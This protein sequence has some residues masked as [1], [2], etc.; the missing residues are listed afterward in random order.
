MFTIIILGYNLA[1]FLIMLST[2][3]IRLSRT[4]DHMSNRPTK[5]WPLDDEH[6][7]IANFCQALQ[8]NNSTRSALIQAHSS[9][10][11]MQYDHQDINLDQVLHQLNEQN[12]RLTQEYETL[13]KEVSDTGEGQKVNGRCES[14]NASKNN[15]NSSNNTSKDD[16]Q[17]KKQGEEI[18][19]TP[20]CDTD[21]AT[22]LRQHTNRMETRIAILVDHNKQLE[23]QLKRLRQLVLLPDDATN[24]GNGSQFGTLRSKVV[25][26]TSLQSQTPE[27]DSGK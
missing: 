27:F 26:A 5:D 17:N 12:V 15:Q 9:N 6:L 11:F 25:R 19:T 14:T 7:I 1:N 16:V 23:V 3:S 18:E 8:D 2:Y 10:N 21:E 24:S 4:P 13:S 20:E 22:R